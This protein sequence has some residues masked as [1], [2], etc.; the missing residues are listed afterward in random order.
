M[1]H[2]IRVQNKLISAL[3]ISTACF[4]TSAQ[5]GLTVNWLDNSANEDGFMIDKRLAGGTAFER[6]AQLGS[7]STTFTDNDVL[8]GES[9]CY[10][11]SAFNAAG[12]AAS[13]E[14]CGTVAAAT[15][16][17]APLPTPEP[18]PEPTPVGFVELSHS[19][20]EQPGQ[21]ELNGKEFYG[22]NSGYAF[23]EAYTTDAIA[24]VSLNAGSGSVSYKTN[25]QFIFSDQGSEL[26]RGYA[27]MKFNTANSLSFDLVA[28]GATQNATLYLKAGAWTNKTAA[29]LVTAGD[30]T[31]RI[32]LPQGRTWFF[33]TTDIT[34][35]QNTQVTITPEGSFGSYS[36]MSFAGI[37]LNNANDATAPDNTDTATDTATGVSYAALN[38]I[39]MN[40]GSTIDV[41]ATKYVTA[42][43]TAGNLAAS[44]A[45]ATFSFAGTGSYSTASFSFQDNGVEV[46]NGYYGMAWSAA[47]AA[48]LSLDGAAGE[49][50]TASVYLKAGAWTDET[51]FI[52]LTVNGEVQTIE[53]PGT[54]S[55][56]YI[57]IDLAFEGSA[58]ISI[59]P[60]GEYGGYSK[61]AIA[62][63][64]LN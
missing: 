3:L 57:R 24:N 41:T 26:D 44:N 13:S 1:T 5:A 21:I 47:N 27:S 18:T 50:H 39:D 61:L 2:A 29:L 56:Y 58:D 4:A 10:R 8:A 37:V 20:I 28:S 62:G 42:D 46:A 49:S 53:L 36:A 60:L 22:F 17:P 6:V 25:D 16:E 64:T 30:K 19:L 32:E 59:Q 63:T 12:E 48:T 38:G 14:M 15:T 33:I 9:Y 7:D 23:N 31:E 35:N 45:D 11:I 52:Q 54:R 55:W 40:A 43:M 34:F 51:P